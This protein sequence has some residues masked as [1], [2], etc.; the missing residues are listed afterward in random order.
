MSRIYAWPMRVTAGRLVTID[1]RSAEAQRQHVAVLLTTRPGE[2]VVV[3]AY[4]TPDPV[5]VRDY[6]VQAVEAAADRWCPEARIDGIDAA[7]DVQDHRRMDVT[8]RVERR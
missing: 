1:A 3:P 5:G 7:L 2:R 4:G 8:V 6:D